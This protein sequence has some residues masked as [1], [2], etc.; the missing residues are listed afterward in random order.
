MNGSLGL[1]WLFRY[2]DFTVDVSAVTAY[3]PSVYPCS[4]SW[5]SGDLPLP[6]R[7]SVCG[8]QPCTRL[9]VYQ[10]AGGAEKTLLWQQSRCGSALLSGSVFPGTLS[11]DSKFNA[12]DS[13]FNVTLNTTLSGSYTMSQIDRKKIR[14]DKW[15]RRF[16]FSGVP[17]GLISIASL[18]LGQ[19]LG[20]SA[21][22]QL[23]IVSATGALV[24]GMA[25]NVRFVILA[26]RQQREQADNAP[27]SD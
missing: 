15:M 5:P 11:P 3:R 19:W 9:P 1:L 22:G 16:M 7:C 26:V 10:M 8:I 4:Q 6:G 23:F 2:D 14:A 20:S 13:A 27:D 12:T 25:Y 21:M 24:I 17:L 18:W